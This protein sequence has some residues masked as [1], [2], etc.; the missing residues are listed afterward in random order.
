MK[1]A[2]AAHAKPINQAAGNG[3]RNSNSVLFQL[4][5]R[6]LND[7]TTC[8]EAFAAV[9]KLVTNGGTGPE[10][11]DFLFH[12][13]TYIALRPKFFSSEQFSTLVNQAMLNEIFSEEEK[14][15][16]S[17]M[18]R[19]RLHL[20]TKG[21][22]KANVE[23]ED[24]GCI[25]NSALFQ[26]LRNSDTCQAAYDIVL[27]LVMN[28]V[29]SKVDL[30]NALKV[31]ATKPERFSNEQVSVIAG[32]ALQN[33]TFSENQ[34]KLFYEMEKKVPGPVRTKGSA[35]AVGR[36][37]AVI[38][39]PVSGAANHPIAITS[40]AGCISNSALFQLLRDSNTCQAAYEIVLKLVM[41][42]VPSKVDL[43]NALKVI[44]TKPERFSN[45][46]VSV[47]AG[48][49]LENSTFSE[50]QR[51]LFSEMKKK[52]PGPVRTKGSAE[53]VGRWSAV[54]KPPVSGAA[55]HPKSIDQAANV[56]DSSSMSLF[57]QLKDPAACQKAYK[58]VLKLVTDGGSVPGMKG[59][60]LSAVIIIASNPKLFSSEQVSFIAGRALL[61]ETFSA[62]QKKLLS[63][64][65]DQNMEQSKRNGCVSG[66]REVELRAV[67]EDTIDRAA[68]LASLKPID[69]AEDTS[70][71]LKPIDKGEDA[72]GRSSSALFEKLQNPNT[73]QDAYEIVLKQL[74]NA[75]VVPGKKDELFNAVQIIASK[76]Q[77]F[78]VEQFSAT[79]SCITQNKVWSD[80][81][82]SLIS[83]R[84][85]ERHGWMG[86]ADPSVP[87]LEINSGAMKGATVIKEAIRWKPVDRNEGVRSN[88]KP[89]LVHGLKEPITS[90]QPDIAV[91]SKTLT[92]NQKSS[93]S[94][95]KKEGLGRIMIN[96]P[97]SAHVQSELNSTAVKDV[98]VDKAATQSNPK[99][100][101]E[102]VLGGSNSSLFQKLKDPNSRQ[103][104]YQMLL[105]LAMNGKSIPGSNNDLF[106]TL[107]FIVSQQLCS[108]FE[109]CSIASRILQNMTLSEKQNKVIS[110]MVAE[111]HYWMGL[112]G[113]PE[114][115]VE[116]H[117][118]TMKEPRSLKHVSQ[119]ENACIESNSVPVQDLEEPNTSQQADS[120]VL[121]KKIMEKQKKPFSEAMRE[122]PSPATTHVPFC[123]Q[124]EV[125]STAV[126]ETT[127]GI[128]ATG[129][130][131]L[132]I[133]QAENACST[134]NSVLLGS[135]K[136]PNQS[137]QAGS[138]TLSKRRKKKK[139]LQQKGPLSE[140]TKEGIDLF[141]T[142]SPLS[143]E[144]EVK[145][146][147]VND[148]T[149]PTVF[150][151]LP[152]YQGEYAFIRSSSSFLQKL[153][154]PT[155]CQEA[156]KT[157][158]EVIAN[159]RSVHEV[160]IDMLDALEVIASNSKLFTEDQISTLAG[161]ALLS[162]MF[163]RKQ[164]TWIS[165]LMAK[166]L[167]KMSEVSS[168]VE[169]Q[170]SAILELRTY[171]TA[172]QPLTEQPVEFSSQRNAITERNC[173]DGY[174]FGRAGWPLS[175][176]PGEYGTVMFP[177]NKLV[178][179]NYQSC[180]LP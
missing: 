31:I 157:V 56:C 85:T 172:S 24:V 130:Y 62:K 140:I 19:T 142:N 16:F 156:F 121:S 5:S 65:K 44:A 169:V 95:I 137:Q 59:D 36:W 146:A 40:N 106:N 46:Q 122:V 152:I 96:F 145:S 153:K 94:E 76:P 79:A 141:R 30:F 98:T 8:Q 158:M 113:P 117:S 81:Q 89:S 80:K 91:L 92:E 38:K 160:T 1:K 151:S 125:N 52:G 71:S 74:A 170:S 43:F 25:S 41:N 120:T 39:P 164:K 129:T 64:L 49:A 109:F 18:N 45:E 118:D 168:E 119:D 72:S 68:K 175:T 66:E 97:L 14:E 47:I 26:L 93:Y 7:P 70:A 83:Q 50:N 28:G 155:T 111:R 12:A 100:Q 103:E 86:L 13:V 102:N 10:R 63:K 178:P 84:M 32:H 136:E 148:A 9:L 67:K 143:A 167:A 54:I 134:S 135:L 55:N 88:F 154:E 73:C 165:E 34:R 147:A 20:R 114:P 179:T 144:S 159:A 57:Q 139:E 77:L 123:A 180:E 60:L 108:D 3:S 22:S 21:R 17:E 37:S 173:K 171:K 78:S 104:A 128:G 150:Y 101:D 33:S 42:G 23:I 2:T 107:E 174:R 27:K 53:A 87:K 82:I 35:E 127:G 110:K 112:T 132:P 166:T 4:L 163:S 116:V 124:S 6:E 126:N 162:K 75:E 48:H 11:K 133:Y 99:D 61:N 105:K 90:Q 58:V 29:P 69:Q 177:F 138:T 115:E 131:S 149:E 51:K 15:L 176:G 161:C